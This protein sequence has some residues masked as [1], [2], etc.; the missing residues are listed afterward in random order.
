MLSRAP[1]KRFSGGR[2]PPKP[3]RR[4]SVS[5][6]NACSP[7]LTIMM[8]TMV[9]IVTGTPRI[10]RARHADHRHAGRDSASASGIDHRLTFDLEFGD[11]KIHFPQGFDRMLQAYLAEKRNLERA[12][13]LTHDRQAYGV[14]LG[15]RR[16]RGVA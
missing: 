12:F 13:H 1:K 2:L 16:E 7:S 15:Y 6:G 10:F 5:G 14:L 9:V 11:L 8:V 4:Y 3:T